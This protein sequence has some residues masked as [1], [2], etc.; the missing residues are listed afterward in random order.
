[1]RIRP[2]LVRGSVTAWAAAENAKGH[3]CQCGC[4]ERIEVIP[5]HWKKGIPKYLV[6]HY[7]RIQTT[8]VAV[9]RGR[10]SGVARRRTTS[11]A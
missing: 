2:I 5:R 10:R 7:F 8:E 3:F 6:R 9:E 4:G 11:E 1:M